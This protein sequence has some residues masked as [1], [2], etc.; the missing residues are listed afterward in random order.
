LFVIKRLSAPVKYVE[1][2]SLNCLAFEQLVTKIL[3][4]KVLSFLIFY[5]FVLFLF[6]PKILIFLLKFLEYLLV[7]TVPVL[8]PTGTGMLP[9]VD[10]EEV[11]F[12]DIR[13]FH[14]PAG[15]YLPVPVHVGIGTVLLLYI[16][17]MPY[18]LHA[19]VLIFINCLNLHCCVVYFIINTLFYNR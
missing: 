7:H 6:S 5:Y 18:L 19:V 10:D 17:R 12:G 9:T 15:F 3:H 16:C 14:T 2:T 13:L 11:S 4:G 1:A 8:V